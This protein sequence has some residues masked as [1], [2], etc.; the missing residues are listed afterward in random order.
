M[1]QTL[2]WTDDGVLFLDQTKLPTEEVYVNCTT[3]QEVADVIRNM[4]V[5]GAPAIGVAAGLGI[6]LGVKN[7]E[8]ATVADLKRDLDQIC[9]VIGKTRPTAVNL[10]WAIRRLQQKFETLRTKPVAEIKREIVQEGKR[11]HAEDIAIN[12]AMGKHGAALMPASGSVLTHCNAGALATAGY[13]TALGVIRAAVE[14]GKKIHVYAD[15]TRPFLQGSRL[16]AWELVKDGIPTTVISDNMSGAMMR[17]GKIGAVIVGADRIAANGDVANKI[18]TYTVAVLAKE[19]GIPFYVAAP[20][21]TVDLE[22]P[23]GSKIPIEQRNAAEVT[24]IAGKRMTPEGV[25]IENPAFDVT[26]AKYVT[27]I[28]TE[29]GIAK[30]PYEES[31][32]RLVVGGDRQHASPSQ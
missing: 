22:T 31:L 16:T 2:E 21:S 14:A 27:A 32:A 4:V 7:S 9:D 11:M 8:A 29:R 20:I 5:R 18:G 28:V 13:G 1:I 10:F 25:G 19:H 3:Y 17:Q 26:P 6:A 15:E 23:D 30:A 12:Q 24:T